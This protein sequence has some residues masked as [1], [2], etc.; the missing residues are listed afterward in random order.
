M[1]TCRLCTAEVIWAMDNYGATVP[2][3]GI[4]MRDRGKGRYWI[5]QDGTRPIVAELP[6]DSE[7]RA[8]VDHRLICAGAA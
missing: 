6:E 5:V 7:R 3:D 2:L 1:A 8:F 4:E